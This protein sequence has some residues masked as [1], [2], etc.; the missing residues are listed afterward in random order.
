MQPELRVLAPHGLTG[1]LFLLLSPG[2]A[3]A[4]ELLEEVIVTGSRIAR[5][6][7]E[8]ASPIVS[9]TEDLFKHTASGTVESSLNTLPQFVPA[10]TASSNNPGNNGQANV[11]LRG[12]GT[13]STLVLVDGR[14]LMPANGNGVADLNIIPSSL[15]ESV[16]I[17]TGGASAV[18]G[19]DALAG[20]VNFKLKRDFDGV[21][22]DGTWGQTDRGDGAQYEAGM[23]VGTDFADG[24]GSI[25][26]YI[27]HADRELV[28]YGDREFSKY[29]LGYAGGPG[30]GSLGP[31]DAFLP[32]GSPTIEEGRVALNGPGR[33]SEQA[34]DDLMVSYGFASGEVP[35][36]GPEI[37]PGGPR[38]T[39]S[40]FGFNAD[41]SLFTTGNFFFSDAQF[42]GVR[43]FRGEPDPVFVSEYLYSYNY[44][45]DNA[46]QLPLERASAFLRAEFEVSEAL[47]FELQGLYADY[48]VTQQLAPAPVMGVFVPVDNPFVP[49]DLKFL[50]D[51]RIDP[52]APFTFDKRLSETGPRTGR[53]QNDV[54][55]VTLG[56]S[57]DIG[58]AWS[59]EGYVQVGGNE[60]ENFQTG[61]VLT[62]RMEELTFAADGGVSICGGFD[63]FGKGSISAECLDYIKVDASNEAAVDQTLAEVSATGPVFT[64][65]AGDAVAA[66][67]VFYKRD[68][69]RYAAS[70]EASLFIGP[71]G[72]PCTPDVACRPDLQ[73]FTASQDI[74]GEDSN[75]DL[76]AE[77]LLPLLRDAPAARSLE[78]VLGYRS[79][80]YDS[81]GRFDS[82][83]A[84]LLYQPVDSLR[85]RGSYQEAVRA[86]S[87]FELYLPQLPA[88]FFFSDNGFADPCTVGSPERTGPDGASVEALCLAQ[89][90]PA[91]SLPTF[92]DSDD[93]ALGVAGG[94]PALTQEDASTTTLGVV[95]TS[96]STHPAL[97]RLQ[98][99]LDWYRIEIADKI[100]AVYFPDFVPYCYD[101]RY[102]PDFSTSNQWCSLFSRDRGTGE[103][104]DVQEINNNSYDW[105]TSGVDVQLDWSIDAGRGQLGINWLVSWLESFSVVVRQSSVPEPPRPGTIGRDVGRALPEWKSSLRVSYAWHDLELGAD[106]RY[107][108]AMRDRDPNLGSVY[109]VPSV[110]YFD[111]GGQYAF[112]G[113]FFDGL[114][115][116][117][118]IENLTDADPPIYPSYIQANT[119]PSQYDPYGRRYYASFRYSF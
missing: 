47:R 88:V 119:D 39:N 93:L 102:N 20:V 61:N 86:P 50:L 117:I 94:N 62:S 33:P 118:G 36:F 31:G 29:A 81:A 49:A 38:V 24:R 89:G 28:T 46:L 53:N 70:P 13:T 98:A 27:G 115:I 79:S 95:W 106:W 77:L 84:E 114:E 10:F 69:Y 37:F 85:V 56:V 65:P 72:E 22:L 23:T 15:I 67:G 40:Q 8:S 42:S 41:R 63:P 76:Y 12:L 108:D 116:G 74:R 17:I 68:E 109:E 34:F 83:K 9:A 57:G 54:Y 5:P 96:A 101:A 71:P 113:G 92:E 73:G 82:W 7:F 78:A 99:S 26:G 107:I 43:N 58:A 6:D 19:S 21:E 18:Y 30:A 105:E 2:P 59:Y 55:Q 25:V 103:I 111:L 80:D 97:A 87:V 110:D 75:L 51:S 91:E 60:Q 45:P 16:E 52:T 44:A 1:M 90:M 100:D 11:S 14:R 3:T 64:L 35:F 66:F 48:S 32:A 4:Q 112:S 104:V